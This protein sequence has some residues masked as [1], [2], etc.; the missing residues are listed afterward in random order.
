MKKFLC[1]PPAPL[2]EGGKC[3]RS[4]IGGSRVR[5]RLPYVQELSE[6]A[7]ELRKNMTDPEQKM[8]YQVLGKKNFEGIRFLRQCPIDNYIVDFYCARL[9]LVIEIDGDSHADQ[10]MYDVRRSKV[11]EG[12]GIK[13]IR[14]NNRD[15][16]NNL[17][18][19]YEDLQLQIS[20]RKKELKK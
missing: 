12:Y 4:G 5:Y 8:W 9:K 20:E 10:E 1:S 13:I 15:V 19:V 16:M 6:R 14:Y 11:L 18:G 3:H 2:I 17:E 7:K